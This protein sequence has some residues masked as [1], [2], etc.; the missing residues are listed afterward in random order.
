LICASFD[1]TRSIGGIGGFLSF[2]PGPFPMQT[3]EIT[4]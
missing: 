2:T 3:T 1:T 4:A